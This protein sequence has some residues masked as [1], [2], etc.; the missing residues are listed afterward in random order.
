M[1]LF[2]II[3]GLAVMLRAIAGMLYLI[4]D[5]GVIKNVMQIRSY[6]SKL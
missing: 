2:I 4:F 5:N 3:V 1:K 6:G